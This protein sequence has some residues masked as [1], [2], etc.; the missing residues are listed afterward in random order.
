[1]TIINSTIVLDKFLN[2]INQNKGIV[3][4]SFTKTNQEKVEIL[5]DDEI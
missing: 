1:M 2:E 5:D 4:T 3:Y